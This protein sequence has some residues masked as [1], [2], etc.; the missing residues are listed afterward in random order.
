MTSYVLE[1]VDLTI[2]RSMLLHA[3]QRHTTLFTHMYSR[4]PNWC[5]SNV[6]ETFALMYTSLILATAFGHPFS[7]PLY[8]FYLHI[9]YSSHPHFSLLLL[10]FLFHF[11]LFKLHSRV[12]FF[13]MQNYGKYVR[14]HSHCTVHPF[15]TI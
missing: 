12:L 15:S 4:A 1:L 8:V 7:I 3:T 6:N 9:H 14:S 11:A 2:A 10:L 13:I 5:S